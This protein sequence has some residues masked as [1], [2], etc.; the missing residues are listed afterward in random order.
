MV[1]RGEPDDPPGNTGNDAGNDT[2][3]DTANDFI[4]VYPNPIGSILNI[5]IESENT[6]TSATYDIRLYNDQ[7]IL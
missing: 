4:K 1:L 7:G 5:E 6:K 3:I 2:G